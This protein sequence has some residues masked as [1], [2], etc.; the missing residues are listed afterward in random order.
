[1]NAAAPRIAL[2]HGRAAVAISVVVVLL[3]VVFAASAY[4][5]APAKDPVSA[6]HVDVVGDSLSTGFKTP[7][8]TWPSEAQALFAGLGLKGQITNASE[9][10]AGYVQPGSGG[11]VFLDLVNRIVNSQSQVVVL[12]G[13]D[14]DAG[15]AGV[16]NAVQATLDRVTVLAPEATVIVVGP[17]SE[18]DDAQGYLASIRQA[19]EAGAAGIGAKFV[20]PV[21]LKWFQGD[22]SKDLASDLEHPNDAGEKYLAEHMST[23]MAPA[24]RQAMHRD[25]MVVSRVRVE[26]PGALR[27]PVGKVHA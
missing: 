2:W 26:A 12:F 10:G 4:A 15:R 24:I 25:R 13:S 19:L 23:I 16:R 17:T 5:S 20:D 7:G 1:M 22:A 6:V 21:N 18:S 9:N 3:V 11:D 14:N 8:D 27:I